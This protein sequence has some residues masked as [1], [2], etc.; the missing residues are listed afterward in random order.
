MSSTRKLLPRA[1]RQ[2]AIDLVATAE[3]RGVSEEER[4]PARQAGWA[5]PTSAAPKSWSSAWTCGYKD[6]KV[7]LGRVVQEAVPKLK[8]LLADD[9]VEAVVIATP[10]HWHTL[11]GIH[12]C[13]AGKDVYVEKPMSYDI[14]EGRKLMEAEG[15]TV[16][17]YGLYEMNEAFAVQVLADGRQLGVDWDRV[18]IRGGAVALGHP[19]GASGARILTTLVHAM[20]DRDVDKGLATLCLGGG[21]AVALVALLVGG[22]QRSAHHL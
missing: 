8:D 22:P 4:A 14:Y 17:D 18:N 3:A 2:E 13:Q 9:N 20:R 11:P 12:A 16:G 1:E 15:S 5:P 10:D 6:N 21:N 19:I 7:G